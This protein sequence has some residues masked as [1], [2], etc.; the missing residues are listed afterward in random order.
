[1]DPHRL[2]EWVTTHVS[3]DDV[4]EGGLDQGSTFGQRMKLAGKGFD[5]HWTVTACEAPNKAAW[6][7][8]GPG[9]STAHVVYQLNEAGMAARALTTRMDLT[10]LAASWGGSPEGSQAAPPPARRPARPWLG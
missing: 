6:E 7:G 8:A 4:P 2:G 1:M 3:V 5:V 9:G 10:C